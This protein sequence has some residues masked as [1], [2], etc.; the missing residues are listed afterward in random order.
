MSTK[1]LNLTL[2]CI[3]KKKWSSILTYYIFPSN[4]ILTLNQHY[5]LNPCQQD[6]S[7]SLLQ[8]FFLPKTAKILK[9]RSGTWKNCDAQITSSCAP[10][11]HQINLSLVL[12]LNF[13]NEDWYLYRIK[14]I[15]LYICIH[16][17][18]KFKCCNYK[19]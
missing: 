18:L 17:Q 5:H 10:S 2:I 6:L 3:T 8:D 1:L 4:K 19:T 12:Y 7:P 14:S 11:N 15:K 16:V 9:H 13:T